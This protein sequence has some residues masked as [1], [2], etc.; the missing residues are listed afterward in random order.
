[1][2]FFNEAEIETRE[3]A[4]EPT[5]E[6]VV[7]YRKKK[8]KGQR[9]ELL[10]DLPREKRF[11]TLVEEDRF[12]ERCNSELHSIGEEFVRTEIE[13]IPAKVRV[14]DYYRETFECRSCRKKGESYIEKAPMPYPVIQHSYASPST[15][16]W[17][18]HQKYEMAIPLY[19]QEKEWETLGVKLSRATMSKWIMAAYRDWLSPVIHLLHQK[20]L[21]EKYLHCDETP[22]QV[23]QETGRKN[24]TDSYMWVYSTGKYSKHPI[25]LFEY[26]PGRGGKYPEA[27]LKGFKG[28]LHTDAYAGYNKVAGVTQCFC[29]SHLRR[30]FVDALPKD[31]KSPEATIPAKAIE[32][33]NKLFKIEQNLEKLS[34]YERKDQRL[35]QE[36]PVLEA[37]WLWAKDTSPKVLPKSK[38]GEAFKYAFNHEEGFMAYLEDGNCSISNNLSENS[39]RPF[40]IG[41]KNWLFSGSPKGA[42]ASAGVYTLIETAKANGLNPT[43]YIEFI[44]SDIPGSAFLEYPEFLED[45]MPW[46]PVIQKICK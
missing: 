25:R 37:F 4:P 12:C 23:L 39:I 14:I 11:C 46:N 32:Y 21:E 10:K 43:K 35:K 19:R 27:F 8:F 44:L 17:V 41:R 15:V 13:F 38:L 29:F 5:L 34:A 28:Y 42:A 1:M 6:D 45:Y 36:K 22:V 9:E 24:T 2:S 31:V 20:L 3:N 16:A 7:S 30:K 18:I 26:Q 40:T 33:I